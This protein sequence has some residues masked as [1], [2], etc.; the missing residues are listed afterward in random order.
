MVTIE[1]RLISKGRELSFDEL[2]DA[3]ADRFASRLSRE[4]R[5]LAQAG[6][7]PPTTP[8]P[9][10]A[11]PEPKAVSVREAARLLSVSAGAV[12][13]FVAAGRLRAVQVGRR[14]LVPMET[15]H[16]ALREGIPALRTGDG[17]GER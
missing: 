9:P 5:Q 10:T 6:P 15:I 3:I 17:R 16:E 11:N 13:R 8:V 4:I 14:V 12:R 2:A 7:N 1:L